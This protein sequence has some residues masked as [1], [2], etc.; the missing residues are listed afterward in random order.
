MEKVHL[1]ELTEDDVLHSY[2]PKNQ[3]DIKSMEEDGEYLEEFEW[4]YTDLNNEVV[5]RRIQITMGMV[6]AF[7]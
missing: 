6:H 1:Q 4:E 3:Y 2:D 5:E 7:V